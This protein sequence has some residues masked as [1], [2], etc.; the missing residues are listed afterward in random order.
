MNTSRIDV[1]N[2]G[3]MLVALGLACVAPYE[4]FLLAYTVLGPLHYLTEIS[5]LHDRKNFCTRRVDTL[6]LVLPTVF[7]FMGWGVM[8]NLWHSPFF[9]AYSAEILVFTFCSA[10]VY[11]SVKNPWIRIAG[12]MAAVGMT[13]LYSMSTDLLGWDLRYWVALYLT[14]LIHVFVF[15]ASFILLGALRNRSWTGIASLVVFV[16]AAV[17]CFA[18]PA[19]SRAPAPGGWARQHFAVFAPMNAG[20]CYLFGLHKSSSRDP[21]MPFHDLG[22]LYESPAAFRAMTFIAFAYLYH[23]LNWF[24]KTKV[25]GWHRISKGRLACILGVWA[26]SVGLYLWSFELALFWLTVLSVSHVTLEFPL[27]WLAFKE[28]ASRVGPLVG[29]KRSP[30]ANT[31]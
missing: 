29:L 10:L 14:T 7:V 8:V 18:N 23:Y 13:V 12:M 16:L 24:S 9:A 20:L 26:A 1:L 11:Q 17:A 4:V 5:W 25:I 6:L 2:I 31:A 3:L 30:K 22:E 21:L 15:T 28:C 19:V 27:N